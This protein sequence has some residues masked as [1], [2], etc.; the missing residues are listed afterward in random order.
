MITVGGTTIGDERIA[1]EVQY[2]PATSLEQARAE[3]ARA[4]VV[5][6][7]L[8]QEARR[9]VPHGEDEDDESLVAWLLERAVRV[10]EPGGAEC[11]RY[12]ERNRDRFTGPTC[13]EAQHILIAAAPDD[14]AERL[15][16]RDR[17]EAL[18]DEVRREPG[19]FEALARIHS[20]CPSGR[21]GGHLGLLTRGQT[22]PEFDNTVF[23]LD[24]GTL[25]PHPLETRYGFHVV[26]VN[27]RVDGAPL[28]FRVARER[29][30]D[31]L[32]EQSWRRAVSQ[33][34]QRLAAHACITGIDLGA[35]DMPLMQ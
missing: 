25:C 21:E 9:Q 16:A 2:H 34:I 13:V 15:A 14:A 23:R 22:V 6:E 18:A 26:R 8:L 10:P 4:L 35:S 3:A 5:R 20:S 30:A 31:Y 24:A 33:Y 29:I 1:R 28:P 7:L 11:R 32:R 19:R 27:R 12:F 17:A